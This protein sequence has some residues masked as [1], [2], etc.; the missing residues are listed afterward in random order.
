[1]NRL[2]KKG[3]EVAGL[4]PGTLVHVGEHKVE[5]VEV[6]FLDYDENSLQEQVVTDLKDCLKLKDKPTVSW[7]NVNGLHDVGIVERL[8]LHYGLHPLVME[9]ILNTGQRPKAEDYEQYLYVVVKM[10]RCD[11][12]SQEIQ[13]EQVS[14]VLG[15]GF[16]LSFQERRGDVFDQVR[17]RIRNSKG[18]IRS[19][20]VDYLLYSLLDSIVDGYFATLE[21]IGERLERL[22]DE[23][24]SDP[25]KNTLQQIHNLKREMVHLR[26]SV[27]PLREAISS[28]QR[29]E[30]G[31]ISPPTRVFL[32]DVYDHTVQ[33]VDTMETLRDMV[34]GLLDTYL[35][36]LSNRMNEIMKVLTII[37]TIF[38]P[39][40]FVAGIY[41][42]NFEYM[43]E[44]GWKLGY[45]LV[46]VVMIGV[47]LA[48]L[49]YFRKKNWL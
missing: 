32:R 36:S 43:P 2:F 22:Q 31:L 8:G 6:S 24:T 26:K 1:M 42:M 48:M 10:L 41:G 28:L 29:S 49:A 12:G 5:Q 47:A 16:V 20:G 44:L 21:A 34:A 13:A 38:I 4:A 18:R 40:T 3:S 27:W 9:D 45:P 19:M 23:V 46:W 35:S 39:L 17:E 14:L 37:A 33:V 30:S 15:S 25:A 7:I 11:E